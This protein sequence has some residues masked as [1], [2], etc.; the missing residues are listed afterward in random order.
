MIFIASTTGGLL[1]GIFWCEV[2][3]ATEV[4]SVDGSLVIIIYNLGMRE[5]CFSPVYIR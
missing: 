2:R 3:Q 4:T 1:L 5:T